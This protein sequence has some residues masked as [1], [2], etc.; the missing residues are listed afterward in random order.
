MG[1]F[2]I[3][4]VYIEIRSDD[5]RVGTKT[6]TL[7]SMGRFV[8]KASGTIIGVFSLVGDDPDYHDPYIEDGAV[9]MALARVHHGPQAGKW[10]GAEGMRVKVGHVIE[11]R[12]VDH[13]DAVSLLSE[14]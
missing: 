7:E 12:I 2:P 10:R 14:L 6:Q 11:I 13:E 5:P 1:L 3:P 9:N 8:S 4:T